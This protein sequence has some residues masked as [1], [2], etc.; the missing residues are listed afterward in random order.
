MKTYRI[1][2]HFTDGLLKGLDYSETT[3][4]RFEVGFV[5]LK[6]VGGS[7]YEI[8]AVEEVP[9]V[10]SIRDRFQASPGAALLAGR[11]DRSVSEGF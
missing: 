10:P 11:F 4:V 7:P 8:T 6:P 3:T 1:T 9:T 2:K 5:C